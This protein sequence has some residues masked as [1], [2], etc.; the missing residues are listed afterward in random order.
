MPDLSFSDPPK[1]HAHSGVTP[2]SYRNPSVH[3]VVLDISF[4]GELSD[5]EL[6][7]VPDALGNQFGDRHR[8]EQ[9]SVTVQTGPSL[10]P[11]VHSESAFVG[12]RFETKTPRWV[13][14]PSRSRLTMHMLRSESWPSGEYVGWDTIK[15][16]F[17]FVL[18]RLGPLYTELQPRRVGL[19]YLNRFAVAEG[20]A[21]EDWLTI[22][23]RAPEPVRKLWNFQ[24][25]NTWAEISGHPGFSATVNLAKIK[26][27]E[28]GSSGKYGVLL[29]I[30][31]FNL[32]PSD[33]PAYSGLTSWFRE[34]HEAENELFEA[35][36]TEN[37]RTTFGV[38]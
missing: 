34:A 29:D 12:W 24:L 7:Q 16:R 14:V 8:L 22:G 20:S 21:L 25:R 5:N 36:I 19:R 37:L 10:P 11:E 9:K 31:V 2:H 13:L 3:E 4:D 35:C 32:F 18:D 15:D 38:L 28:T 27:P 33:A 17:F 30:D 23:V 6:D 26:V 1:P